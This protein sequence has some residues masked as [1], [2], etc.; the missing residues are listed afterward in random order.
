MFLSFDTELED[1]RQCRDPPATSL[2]S[3]GAKSHSGKGGFY[4]G[5]EGSRLKIQAMNHS[6]ES[7]LQRAILF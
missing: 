7:F 1:H 3:L 4:E 5:S 6:L 2:D